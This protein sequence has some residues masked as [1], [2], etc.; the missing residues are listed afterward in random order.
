MMGL[1]KK[2]GFTLVEAAITVFLTGLIII[3]MLHMMTNTRDSN[4][5]AG[6]SVAQMVGQ[7][8][9]QVLASGGILDE[10]LSGMM[11]KTN[12]M[13]SCFGLDALPAD[14]ELRNSP[15]CEA[16]LPGGNKRFTHEWQLQQ[17]VIGTTYG[18]N[19]ITLPEGNRY[20]KGVVK[21]YNAPKDKVVSASLEPFQILPFSFFFNQARPA[22]TQ[23]NLITS[24]SMDRS[25]SMS[26]TDANTTG[27]SRIEWARAAL[28]YFSS[29]LANNK[30]VNVN[31]SR[32]GF[33][34]WSNNATIGIRPA[35]GTTPEIPFTNDFASAK[36]EFSKINQDIN[37]DVFPAGQS[38]LNL[39]VTVPKQMYNASPQYYT[40]DYDKLVILLTDGEDTVGT[41]DATIEQSA[42]ANFGWGL[43]KNRENERASVF[44]VG[45]MKGSLTNE[46]GVRMMQ[47]VA[48]ATPWGIYY[49]VSNASKLE[50]IF[51]SI[52]GN[53]EVFAMLKKGK[54]WGITP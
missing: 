24:V 7:L 36:T 37:F 11:D 31:N 3:P 52:N 51:T 35:N 47:R 17:M 43:P 39:A 30:F 45:L 42:R 13:L 5:N 21:I 6:G 16:T 38:D 41:A 12:P 27:L 29:Q 48:S 10:S 1:H 46:S 18:A 8:N 28:E 15:K 44:I 14:S 9:R 22:L 34:S 50:E 23:T 2:Q 54:R 19:N 4:T 33:V 53:I 25:G 26:M 32:V 49:A 40:K 20:Y